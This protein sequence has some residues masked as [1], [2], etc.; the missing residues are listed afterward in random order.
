V[1]TL[2][3]SA[4]FLFLAVP[5]N[6]IINLRTAPFTS[7]AEAEPVDL[8]AEPGAKLLAYD[9]EDF[10]ATAG[11]SVALRLYWQA[12]QKLE[13]NAQVRLVLISVETGRTVLFTPYHHPAG[14]PMRQWPSD[15]FIT[16]TIRVNLP[17]GLLPGSYQFAVEIAACDAA[18]C[19][20]PQVL[21]FRTQREDAGLSRALLPTTVN[22]AAP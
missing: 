14:I 1:V 3:V 4:A 16:D 9:I 18:P 10:R 11:N 15:R 20:Q 6:G 13:Q 19:L 2:V 7:L 12:Q 21:R 17:G 5:E 8:V 22:I